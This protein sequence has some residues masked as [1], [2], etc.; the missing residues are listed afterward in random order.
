MSKIL[1][2]SKAVKKGMRFERL[3]IAGQP[4]SVY[5]KSKKKLKELLCVCKCDCGNVKVVCLSSLTRT[6]QPY[7][8]CGC[9]G[10]DKNSTQG[11]GSNLEPR[12]LQIYKGIIHR[13]YNK[14]RKA[15]KDYGGRGILM[16]DEWRND[17]WA[18]VRWARANGYSDD[19]EIDRRDNNQWYSPSNCR[20]VTTK[21]NA[22][23]TRSN[24]IVT[25][26]GEDKCVAEWAEDSRCV[27]KYGTLLNRIDKGWNPEAAITH[28]VHKKEIQWTPTQT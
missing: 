10:R 16:C 26:F 21:V 20:W 7:R 27:V 6:R 25:A 14:K 4:F 28:P 2:D 24:R 8:S 1:V 11:N 17:F 5:S 12:L 15:Y 13:C 22:R 3:V 18:F 19:L 23:N 9:F